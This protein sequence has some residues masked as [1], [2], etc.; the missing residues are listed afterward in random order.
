MPESNNLFAFVYQKTDDEA[1]V[2]TVMN[3]QVDK[4]MQNILHASKLLE[5]RFTIEQ[6]L[7]LDIPTYESIVSNEFHNIDESY[8]EF[9]SGHINAYTKNETTKLDESLLKNL[10]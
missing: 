1:P 6:L 4:I 3:K 9:K 5:G 10:K 2:R 7:A 8:K